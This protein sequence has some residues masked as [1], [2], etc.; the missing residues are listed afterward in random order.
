MIEP[1]QK[2][3]SKQINKRVDRLHVQ[4]CTLTGTVSTR[5]CM[6]ICKLLN[7][8]NNMLMN[9]EKEISDR[10]SELSDSTHVYRPRRWTLYTV[11][12]SFSKLSLQDHCTNENS[13][14]PQ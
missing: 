13:L 10:Y 1:Q 8:I 7:Y 9:A 2:N 6:I 14:L 4:V 3:I 12:C 11:H 5:S